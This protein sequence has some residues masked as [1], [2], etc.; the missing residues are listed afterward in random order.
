[1]D[2]VGPAALRREHRRAA[3]HRRV[4]RRLV[5]AL[6]ERVQGC[7]QHPVEQQ[8][9]GGAVGFAT[10][11]H[12]VIELDVGLH[13]EPPRGGGGD[14]YQ[15]RLHRAGDQ[16]RV[17]AAL[18][19]FAEVELDLAHLVAAERE[20]GAVVALDPQIDAERRAQVRGE[21]D[22]RRRMAEPDPR[23]AG[24]AGKRA[25]HGGNRPVRWSDREV[26]QVARDRCRPAPAN[27]S[28]FRRKRRSPGRRLVASIP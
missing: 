3:F 9:A 24:D 28:G 26:S 22:R 12:P 13:P 1:M 23:E 17:G 2:D 15:V 5:L 14:P 18:L 8:V 10:V 27:A 4:R 25:G 20:A 6:R 7:A 16:H 19:S 21:I 11:R